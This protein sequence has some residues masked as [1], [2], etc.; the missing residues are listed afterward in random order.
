MS[1][2]TER[3]WAMGHFNLVKCVAPCL[4]RLPARLPEITGRARRL[5]PG[6]SGH[7]RP[8]TKGKL[9]RQEESPVELRFEIEFEKPC[10]AG[11]NG[12]RSRR[13]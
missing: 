12:P 4:S 5:Q 3:L 10:K 9:L 6:W 13:K 7:A 2:E 1:C 8:L 11:M